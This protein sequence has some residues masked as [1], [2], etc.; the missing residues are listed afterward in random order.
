MN[1]GKRRSSS[2]SRKLSTTSR[3][4]RS[5]NGSTSKDGG[6]AL[7][8]TPPS[9]LKWDE[10]NILLHEQNK[11]PRMKIDEPKTP[12]APHYDP[13]ADDDLDME[14]DIPG[15]DIGEAAD[16]GMGGQGSRSM[17][18]GGLISRSPPSNASVSAAAV[19]A[20][21]GRRLSASSHGSGTASEK[22][23]GVNP[24]DASPAHDAEH[25]PQSE[26][27]RRKHCDF[28]MK[29]KRHYEMTGIKDLLGKAIDMDEEDDD[30]DDEM[31][32]KSVPPPMPPIPE[33]FKSQQK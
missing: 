15:L 9:H 28:E 10:T 19:S 4:G 14:G 12:F 5:M 26:D 21:S 23:V 1:A 33:R 27:E 25:E 8:Q 3:S 22:H 16:V 6:A 29:R 18:W 17:E 20:G 30:E 7:P 2:V 24:K 11:V 13:D 32:D 31:E